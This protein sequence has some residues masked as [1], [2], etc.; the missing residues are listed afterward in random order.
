MNELLVFYTGRSHL[1]SGTNIPR[2]E[3]KEYQVRQKIMLK[4]C[5]EYTPVLVGCIRLYLCAH[6]WA[7]HV[8]VNWN[9]DFW[10]EED[11]SIV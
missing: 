3:G 4:R 7:S 11:F 8:T 1:C 2:A 6:E 10:D 9:V 5:S